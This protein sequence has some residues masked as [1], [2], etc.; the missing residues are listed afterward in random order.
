MNKF[1][2]AIAALVMALVAALL[3]GLTQ[4]S[5]SA[6]NCSTFDNS[7]SA[8]RYAPYGTINADWRLY[9]WLTYRDCSNGFEARQYRM[10]IV[11]YNPGDCFKLRGW[12]VNP[13]LIGNYNPGTRKRGCDGDSEQEIVWNLYQERIPFGSDAHERCIGAKVTMDIRLADDKHFDMPSLCVPI[14]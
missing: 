7:K 14:S 1:K 8:N 4:K 10:K 11:P 2:I 3:V 13:N 6:A 12:R 5:A 9:V